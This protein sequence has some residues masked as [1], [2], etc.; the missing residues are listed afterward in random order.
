MLLGLSLQGCDGGGPRP[1]RS[2]LDF[3]SAAPIHHL[4]ATQANTPV[5]SQINMPFTD[6]TGLTLPPIAMAPPCSAGYEVAAGESQRSAR[7]FGHPTAWH[8]R[9]RSLNMP[10]LVRDLS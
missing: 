2:F 1:S 4:A 9:Q 3:S 8:Q 7:S 10:L 5:I 6:N